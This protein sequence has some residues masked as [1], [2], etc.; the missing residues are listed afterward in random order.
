MISYG[1]RTELWG[2]CHTV[3]LAGPA[4]GETVATSLLSLSWRLIS[5]ENL[6]DNWSHSNVQSV[7]W[8]G[9][10]LL[11]LLRNSTSSET[12]CCQYFM[13]ESDQHLNWIKQQK[14]QNTKKY[15]RLTKHKHTRWKWNRF[16]VKYDNIILKLNYYLL[17]LV[18]KPPKSRKHFQWINRMHFFPCKS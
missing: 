10:A 12:V 6:G 17:Y 1:E 18:K 8:H 16:H 15:T 2:L 7:Q 11:G 4:V 3:T 14:H 13:A 9:T 5:S